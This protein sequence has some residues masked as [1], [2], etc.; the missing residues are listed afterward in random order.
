MQTAIEAKFV[1][2]LLEADEE[3]PA[4]YHDEYRKHFGVRGSD[5]GKKWETLED[6]SEFRFAEAGAG[7]VGV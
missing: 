1:I 4:K 2:K 5:W 6:Y 7:Y 3:L